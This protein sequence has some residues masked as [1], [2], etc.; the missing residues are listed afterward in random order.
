MAYKDLGPLVSQNPQAVAP[1]GGQFT[2]ED[3]SW[4]SVVLQQDKP[5]TDWEM[6]LLQDVLGA[7]GIRSLAQK[8][9]PSCFLTNTFLDRSDTL[10]D[11]VFLTPDPVTA[12]TANKFWMRAANL[13]LNGWLV[14][15]DLTELATPG[16]NQ[17]TLP[18][19]P[20]SGGRTDLVVLEAWRA[21]VGPQPDMTNKSPSGQILRYGNAKAPDAGPPGNVCLGDDLIDPTF[22]AETSR[23][24]QIQYRY[25]VIPGVNIDTYPDG[26]DDPLAVAHTTP[27]LGGSTVD[28]N[29]SAY[30]F[31]RHPSDPGLWVAGAN[32][33]AGAGALGTA[34]GLMYAVPV[35]AVFRR[36][37]GPFDRTSN[38][39]GGAGMASPTTDR[40]DGLY[41]DQVAPDD[42][43]DLRRGVAWDLSEAMDKTFQE[44]LDNSLSTRSESFEGSS[45]TS[46]FVRDD[47]AAGSKMGQTDG[48]RATFSDRSVT[49][50]VIIPKKVIA[51]T[52]TVVFNL[53]GV[54]P[55]WASAPSDLT[56]V[57]PPGTGFSGTGRVRV[58]DF[59]TNVDYDAME[60][61]LSP[62]VVSAVLSGGPPCTTLTLT[63]SANISSVFV[64]AEVLVT[65][66]PGNGARRN[67]AG[68]FDLW[69]PSAAVMDTWVDPAAL[70]ATTDP[71]RFSLDGSMW[72][73]DP[74]HR[75]LTARAPSLGL[76]WTAFAD[77]VTNVV[78]VPDMVAEG[79]AP[80]VGGG[81]GIASWTSGTNYTAFTLTSV[82]AA[83]T[84]VAITY[85]AW[86]PL[87]KLQAPPGDSYQLF[88]QSRALQ[89]NAVPAGAQTL[90]LVPRAV[91]KS[92]HVIQSGSASPDDGF[93]YVA[94]SA[95]IPI[96]VIPSVAET[97][98]DSP[99]QMT[100]SGLSISTGYLA[101]PA[102]VP[103]SPSA[104][105]VT[106]FSD[107][108]DV[109]VDADGRNFWPKSDDGSVPLYSP[110]AFAQ[111]LST[112]V[113]HKTAVPVLM[114]VRRDFPASPPFQ[115]RRGTMVLVVFTNWADFDDQNSVELQPSVS[116]TCAAVYRVRGN[117]LNPRRTE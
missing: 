51:P 36:N 38:R 25:R 117:M 27:Y 68:D 81:L 3:H 95:Q 112:K 62:Y 70:T 54:K 101:L 79:S 21:V 96:G 35:C 115:L 16:F 2:A 31:L 88:Y 102:L 15:F 90:L 108:P 5:A 17:V 33:P 111:G 4:E 66:P 109:T 84:P 89:S 32:S 11:Y 30:G 72:R 105:Q 52:N 48:V 76:T 6:N 47:L 64:Y 80:S 104:S 65:Y 59:G 99:A 56:V 93:P 106:L 13:V 46:V 1:G 55:W 85:V 57:A 114:E 45:G 29:P 63:F 8:T 100:V 18:A 107:A 74:G 87:P 26:L 53:S 14:R 98:L 83:G 77:G 110:T 86:R 19:P 44:V 75:E 103:Y 42:V 60:P 58:Y 37:S 50:S 20:L 22:L 61:G 92:V 9:L 10:G 97:V 43:L 41:C 24:V 34:D 91:G 113:R 49:E 39:N 82:P 69:T 7:Y 40:P 71:D 116:S 23:R 28:G 94:P 12:L 78:Y 67:M 73:T